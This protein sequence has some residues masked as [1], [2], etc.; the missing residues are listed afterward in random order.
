MKVRKPNNNDAIKRE[1]INTNR[2]D[3]KL[4][5]KRVNNTMVAQENPISSFISSTAVTTSIEKETSTKNTINRKNLT[6]LN[7]MPGLCEISVVS[8]I[9]S[10]IT[11]YMFVFYVT[12]E[13]ISLFAFF[14]LYVHH[15]C[16]EVPLSAIKHQSYPPFIPP[17]LP[18]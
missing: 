7:A 17:L 10:V 3:I 13:Y 9:V 15:L 1:V 2:G 18:I 8:P 14:S 16:S 5:I 12:I 11:V 6:I 4:K